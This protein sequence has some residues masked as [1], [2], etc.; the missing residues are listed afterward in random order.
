MQCRSPGLAGPRKAASESAAALV[1]DEAGA[2]PANLWPVSESARGLVVE[3]KFIPSR[4]RP[5]RISGCSRDG[6]A[7]HSAAR[8][9]QGFLK[10]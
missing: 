4:R 2:P 8:S 10:R 3:N 5:R 9:S 6:V 1:S 7:Q